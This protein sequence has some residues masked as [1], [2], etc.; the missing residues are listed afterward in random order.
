[1]AARFASNAITILVAEGSSPERRAQVLAEAA[2]SGLAT[3]ISTGVAS[4]RYT[5]FVDGVEGVAEDLVKPEGTIAYRF[6]YMGEVVEFALAFLQ[7]RSPYKGGSEFHYRDNF[8]VAVNGRPLPAQGVNAASIPA[9]AS[10]FIYNSLPYGR[11]VDVQLIGKKPMRFT[12]KAGLFDDAELAV[13]A[14]YGNLVTVARRYTVD[15][16]GRW[17][18]TKTKTPGRKV[19]YPA[20]EITLR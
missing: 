13:K 2:R 19:E 6:A 5:R 16:P 8:V 17:I 11:K 7:A 4:S 12:V 1:M 9:D 20:L 15:F 14:R 3:L 10:I 18:T